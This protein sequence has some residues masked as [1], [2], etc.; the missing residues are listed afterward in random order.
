MATI[1]L[2]HADLNLFE[3]Y[4]AT[5]LPLVARYG[6]RLEMRVRA[7]DGSS[8][9][10][11]L[12]FPDGHSYEAYRSDPDRVAVLDQWERCGA[13]ASVVEVEVFPPGGF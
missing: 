4:E 1:D 11:L 2:T 9:T 10:H 6:G 7:S 5:V 12:Y 8:E 13:R 3:S